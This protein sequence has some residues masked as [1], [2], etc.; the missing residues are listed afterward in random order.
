MKAVLL[1]IIALCSQPATSFSTNGISQSSKVSSLKA[2]NDNNVILSGVAAAVIATA[3]V[4]PDTAMAYDSYYGNIHD[5]GASTELLA[6]RS[7]GRAGGRSSAPR[8]MPRSTRSTGGASST[9]RNYSSTTVVQPP[10]TIV[11]PASTTVIMGSPFGY[12]PFGGYGKF[13]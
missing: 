9:V 13:K 12:S 7:G 3:V 6:A 8:S 10:T 1:A 11:R 2:S 4:A 5:F